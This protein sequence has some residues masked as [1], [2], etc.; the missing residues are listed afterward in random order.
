MQTMPR[1][2]QE[3]LNEGRVSRNRVDA[4]GPAE[5]EA[6]AHKNHSRRSIFR[7]FSVPERR[8]FRRHLR[9]GV[10][11]RGH[12]VEIRPAILWNAALSHRKGD[13]CSGVRSKLNFDA[14]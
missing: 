5:E 3:D 1:S 9:Q 2:P 12:D 14:G 8:C 10:W 7:P 4:D 6:E 13:A 11:D